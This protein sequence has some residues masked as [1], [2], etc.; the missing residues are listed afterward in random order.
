[1]EVV[2]FRLDDVVMEV[3]SRVVGH[4]LRDFFDGASPARD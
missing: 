3:K 4:D 2:G 1:V